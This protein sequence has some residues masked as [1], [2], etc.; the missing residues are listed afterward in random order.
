MIRRICT[1]VTF[2]SYFETLF[3]CEYSYRVPCFLGVFVNRARGYSL[4]HGTEEQ[5]SRGCVR[6][7][8]SML[9]EASLMMAVARCI[10]FYVFIHRSLISCACCR[11]R[12]GGEVARAAIGALE[13]QCGLSAAHDLECERSLAQH[14]AHPPEQQQRQQRVQQQQQCPCAGILHSLRRHRAHVVVQLT[15]QP[16]PSASTRAQ[17]QQK[18]PASRQLAR[19][20]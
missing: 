11:L 3:F 19:T 17:Q 4:S 7:V 10:C 13:G 6:Y 14:S 1:Q 2:S 16:P 12:C 9:L 18:Q 8:M 5:D 20:R 15:L